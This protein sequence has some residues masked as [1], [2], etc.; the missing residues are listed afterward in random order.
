MQCTT[1]K[2]GSECFFMSTSGCSFTGGACNPVVEQCE[3][4]DNI[5]MQ[6]SGRFCRVYADP[7]AKWAFGSCNFATHVKAPQQVETKA[8]N[9]L[10][11]SK[12]AA[13]GR[14]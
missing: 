13:A 14:R 5:T 7:T 9:P 10:K 2:Q 6:S 1:I 12:R 3:G 4:C 8:I 11:A